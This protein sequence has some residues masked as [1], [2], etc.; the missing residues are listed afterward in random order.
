LPYR[1]DDCIRSRFGG[2]F[3]RLLHGLF[4]HGLWLFRQR[5]RHGRELRGLL[6]CGLLCGGVLRDGSGLVLR[7]VR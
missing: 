1:G 7:F 6:R 5:L 2:E 4:V 3:L